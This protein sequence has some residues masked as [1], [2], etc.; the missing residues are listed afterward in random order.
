MRHRPCPRP[1]GL[2]DLRQRRRQLGR[3]ERGQA[4]AHRQVGGPGGKGRRSPA[5]RRW[6]TQA[7]TPSGSSIWAMTIVCPSCASTSAIV[8]VAKPA[9]RV[10][11]QIPGAPAEMGGL[12]DAF[13][14]GDR[15]DMRL[16][17]AHRT[18]IKRDQDILGAAPTARAQGRAHPARVRRQGRHPAAP[19]SQRHVRYR[20]KE[21]EAGGSPAPRSPS[22]R[23]SWTKVP[24]STSAASIR[25]F[26]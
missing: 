22:H 15:I 23:P 26:S 11:R 2:P 8:R 1:G 12:G 24:A 20:G 14:L 4:K 5:P 6:R 17:D 10:D 7:S 25:D 9:Q 16:D 18:G 3:A 13:R 21:I 19:R